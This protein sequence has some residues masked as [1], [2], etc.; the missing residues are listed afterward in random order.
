MERDYPILNKIKAPND[1]KKLSKKELAEL[2]REIRHFLVKAVSENGGH[3]SSNLGVVELTMA[4]HLFLDF[5]EDRLV[6]DV[7]HQ[8]YVHK[9]LTGRKDFS[10]LRKHGGLSGFPKTAESDCDAFDT[11][12]SSTSLSIAAGLAAARDL[13]NEKHKVV[14]LIGDGALGG[15]LSYEAMNNLIKL[16]S[17]LIIVLND[18]SMSIDKN[19]GGMANYLGHIRTN[20][21]YINFKNS[22][23]NMLNQVPV[24]TKVLTKMKHSKN[25]IKSM[26][27][28]GM[29]FEDL[30]ITYIG[31]IDGHN[32]SQVLSALES[33]ER[34]D[35]PILIHCVTK[36]GKGYH[37]AEENPGKFHGVAPFDIKTGKLI[38]KPVLKTYTETFSEE[39]TKLS[40]KDDKIVCITAAMEFGTGL[41]EFSKKF[42]DR[43]FDVGIAEQH[44]V[45]FASALAKEGFKPV[46]AIYS[47][48][49]QR[50]YDQILHDTALTDQHVVF[51]LDRAGVTGADGETHQGIFDLSFLSHIP[52][53]TVMAPKNCEELK[54]MLRFALNEKG[55]VAIRYTKYTETDAVA[56]LPSEDIAHGKAEKLRD[57][58]DMCIFAVGSVTDLGLELA[59]MLSKDGVSCGVYNAR[60]VA[61]LDTEAV[62]EAGKKYKTVVTLEENV[63]SGG[64][65]ERVA[66]VMET[67]DLPAKLVIGALDDKFIEQGSRDEL[68]KLHGLN[69]E[70]IAD[71]IR[72][73]IG[74]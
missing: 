40:E 46:V 16:K 68:L 44:A 26:F 73:S 61:P 55:P 54:A 21:A 33:A 62:K 13:K 64:F 60:F 20:T 41:N 71:E 12:H 72:R 56:S 47:S 43:F 29:F 6:F 3:L 58:K 34:V 52:N 14:A 57:G 37:F 30:G 11:G 22:L 49:L 70:E 31:P 9:L 42:P 5:P 69:L 39:I 15:G 4:L 59:D 25:V 17:N 66:D 51:M 50:S 7:G 24:G 28:A 36:K 67:F 19:V 35:H 74:K 53:M 8:S 45:T 38:K 32:V 18:N 63:R 27:V 10:N 65:G 48:F 2:P 23:A 1:I